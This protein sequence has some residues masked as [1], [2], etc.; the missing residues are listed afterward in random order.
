LSST[1]YIIVNADDLGASAEINNSVFDLMRRG[2]VTSAT[3][4]ANGPAFGAAAIQSFDYPKCSFGVHLNIAEFKP[5]TLSRTFEEVL[6]NNG[7]FSNKI[8]NLQFGPLLR[9]AIFDEWCTQIQRIQAHGIRVS[10]IDSHCHTH[11]IPQ[12]FVVLKKVQKRFHIRKV[13]ISKNIYSDDMPISSTILFFKKALWN[14]TLRKCYRTK[15]TSGFTDFYSFLKAAKI[16]NLSHRTIEVM[17]HPGNPNYAEELAYLRDAWLSGLPFK[18][19]LINY[20][21]L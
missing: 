4:L 7:C 9:D 14:F 18:V 21:M 3:L 5:L 10:H 16:S 6:D 20:D 17:V 11:T 2:V 13:R 15:T 12:L 19:R 8:W 1:V